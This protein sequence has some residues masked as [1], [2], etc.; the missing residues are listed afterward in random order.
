MAISS[1]LAR[2][3]TDHA[4]A[5]SWAAFKSG[6]GST[7]TAATFAA[8]LNAKGYQVGEAEIAAGQ[9]LGRQWALSDG[10]LEGVVGGQEMD[11]NALLSMIKEATA[12]VAPELARQAGLYVDANGQLGYDTKIVDNFQTQ[13]LMNGL[14]Q[15]SD[16]ST[17]AVSGA[18][19]AIGGMAKKS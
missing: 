5:E 7:P 19:S 8:A 14:Y 18:S 13:I 15:L 9:E 4:T 3:L 2:F 10:Q 1:E 16:M 6:V 17:G 12:H 11:V